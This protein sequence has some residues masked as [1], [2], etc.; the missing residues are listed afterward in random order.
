M[1][2]DR[3]LVESNWQLLLME[4][5][6]NLF[7]RED[8]LCGVGVSIRPQ[9]GDRFEIWTRDAADSEAVME[10]GKHLRN[11]FK[12]PSTTKITYTKH[13]KNKSTSF[14]NDFEA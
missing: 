11:T 9:N 12:I 4:C 13:I 2:V 6:G 7:P 5:V 8:T 14:V 10:V 1:M 3:S